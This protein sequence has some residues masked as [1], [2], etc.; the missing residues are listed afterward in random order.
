M[1]VCAGWV[2]T[3]VR[4]T[5]CTCACFIL[6][7]CSAKNYII[8]FCSITAIDMITYGH[9]FIGLRVNLTISDNNIGNSNGT[10]HSYSGNNVLFNVSYR[11]NEYFHEF[12]NGS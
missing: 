2:F 7:L 1:W 3:C 10:G 6:P 9:C 11:Q 8:R 5:V 12:G 4:A